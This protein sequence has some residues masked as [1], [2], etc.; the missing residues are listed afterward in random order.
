MPVARSTHSNRTNSH[1]IP[2]EMAAVV[3]QRNTSNDYHGTTPKEMIADHTLAEEIIKRHNDPCP[4]FDDPSILLLRE[5][6]QDPSKA[7]A[8]LQR[9]DLDEKTAQVQKT[10]LV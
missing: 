10:C 5:F 4:I 7:R 8:L 6:V 9:L 3:P 2:L 1:E